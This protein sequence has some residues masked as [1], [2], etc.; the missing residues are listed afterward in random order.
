MGSS[1]S[2]H[3]K[4]ILITCGPTWIP[5]D[6]VRV[7]SNISTGTLGHWIAQEC[8]RAQAK[9]TLLEGPV[10]KTFSSKN[11][12]LLKFFYYNDLF[13]LIKKELTRKYDIVIHAAAVSD[14]QLPKVFSG[15]ISS[16]KKQLNLRIWHWL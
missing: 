14:Y 4:K 13:K 3:N 11:T 16:N 2:L 9:I 8:L 5:I 15:K 6:G 10:S 7:L 12:T 1:K